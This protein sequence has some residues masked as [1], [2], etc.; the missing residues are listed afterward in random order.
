MGKNRDKDQ[1]LNIVPY[2]IACCIFRKN[3]FEIFIQKMALIINSILSLT[4][5]II[6]F[7]CLPLCFILALE[8]TLIS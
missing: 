1:L 3:I 6:C 4:F 7:P 5:F 8:I 2:C